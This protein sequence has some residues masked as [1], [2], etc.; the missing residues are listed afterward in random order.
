L[1]TSFI[2]VVSEFS[3]SAIGASELADRHLPAV[4]LSSPKRVWA[5]TYLRPIHMML[6]WSAVFNHLWLQISVCK[7]VKFNLPDKSVS[8]FTGGDLNG[9]FWAYPEV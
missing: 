4:S 1:F 7:N 2:R 6:F 8:G 5:H 9:G 3:C